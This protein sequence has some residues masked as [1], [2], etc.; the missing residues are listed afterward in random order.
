MT[1]DKDECISW[2]GITILEAQPTPEVMLVS[3]FLYDWKSQLPEAWREDA[4]L[5][6]IKVDWPDAPTNRSLT[7]LVY[8]ANTTPLKKAELFLA[9]VQASLIP[10]SQRPTLVESVLANGT[11]NSRTQ[12]VKQAIIQL[13]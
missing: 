11:R 8:R 9:T 2:V 3:E 10:P 6:V 5:E 12:D 7:D 13:F 1:I 4:T